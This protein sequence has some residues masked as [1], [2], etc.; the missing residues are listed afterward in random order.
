ML[1]FPLLD[2]KAVA[3]KFEVAVQNSDGRSQPCLRTSAFQ[4][5]KYM[6]TDIEIRFT[7]AALMAD[8]DALPFAHDRHLDGQ[9]R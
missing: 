5:F 3:S 6:D 7:R 1:K 2:L 4:A 8:P 9:C